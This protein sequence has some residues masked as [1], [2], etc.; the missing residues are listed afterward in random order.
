MIN[1]C[2]L[3]NTIILIIKKSIVVFDPF[4]I[5]MRIRENKKMRMFNLA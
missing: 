1:I 3:K 2:K 4:D 5:L